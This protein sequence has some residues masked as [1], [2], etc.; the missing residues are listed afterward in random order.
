[1]EVKGSAIL[2]FLNKTC[3]RGVYREGPHGFNVPFGHYKNPG[4]LEEEHI[5]D[6]SDLIKDVVF[7]VEPFRES[8]QR[9]K[10]GDFVYMDPPYAPVNDTSFV[11]YNVDGFG[12]EEHNSLFGWCRDLHK[13]KVLFVMSNADV[14]LVK[15]AFSGPVYHIES[16]LCRRAIHSKNP[17]STVNEVLI[18]NQRIV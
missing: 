8:L 4:V 1:M 3:F 6:V 17:E 12:L 10:A 11:K 16:I 15:E 18:T 2:L 5:K 7:R 14:P 9:V 13:K